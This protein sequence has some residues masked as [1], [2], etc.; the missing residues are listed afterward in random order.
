MYPV[1]QH[2][3]YHLIIELFF[4]CVGLHNINTSLCVQRQYLFQE[5]KAKSIQMGFS[6]LRVAKAKRSI[7]ESVFS[8]LIKS[9]LK[10]WYFCSSL[11][12]Q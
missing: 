11:S 3:L 8:E 10:H 4:S 5:T 6:Y 7:V 1:H 2:Y 9:E 12:K